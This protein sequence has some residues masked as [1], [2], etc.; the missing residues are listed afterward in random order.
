MFFNKLWE[1]YPTLFIK[2]IEQL[3]LEFTGISCHSVS[4]I[5]NENKKNCKLVTPGKKRKHEQTVIR[6]FDES[7]KN[8]VC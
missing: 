2:D 5:W 1:K 8:A 7:A 4:N 3:L 6:K